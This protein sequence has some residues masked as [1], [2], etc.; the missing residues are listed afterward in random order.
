MTRG[1]NIWIAVM[2]LVT[3]PLVWVVFVAPAARGEHEQWVAVSNGWVVMCADCVPG[4]SI[5]LTWSAPDGSTGP[6]VFEQESAGRAARL[7]HDTYG[8]DWVAR[9]H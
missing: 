6:M 2:A 8:S 9:E 1:M 5:T 3:A 4:D 7:M